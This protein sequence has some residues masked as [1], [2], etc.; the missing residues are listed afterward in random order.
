MKPS[1]DQ[2]YMNLVEVI[3][4]RSPDPITKVG[5]VMVSNEDHR[6]ISSGYNS[7]NP[8]VSDLL[9]DWSDRESV[10]KL[11][12]HAE[13]NCIL[14]CKSRFE[15]STL[16]INLSPCKECIKIIAASN[17]KRVVYKNEYKDID[18]VKALC[19]FFGVSLEKFQTN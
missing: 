17:I 2:Y 14:Y 9:I 1:W 5:S 3:K 4:T 11:I 18:E 19:A 6:I 15:L 7:T 16:Y 13:M 12:I 8:G 10:R